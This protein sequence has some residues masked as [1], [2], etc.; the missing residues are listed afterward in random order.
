MPPAGGG[1]TRARQRKRVPSPAAY[2]VSQGKAVQHVANQQ[3]RA[4]RPWQPTKTQLRSALAQRREHVSQGQAVR[5]VAKVQ[6]VLGPGKAPTVRSYHRREIA[7]ANRAQD[8]VDQGK[9]VEHAAHQQRAKRKAEAR[10]LA[11]ENIGKIQPPTRGVYNPKDVALYA[12]LIDKHG[13]SQASKIFKTHKEVRDAASKAKAVKVLEQVMRPGYASAGGARALVKGQGIKGVARGISRGAQ[14]KDRYLYSD[15]LKEAGVKNKTVRGVAGFGLDILLDPTTY[16]TFGAGSVA[17]KT[18]VKAAIRSAERGAQI[19]A[20]RLAPKVAAGDLTRKEAKAQVAAKGDQLKRSLLRKA[21]REGR[22]GGRKGLTVKVAGGKH[23][24]KAIRRAGLESKRA[25]LAPV[26]RATAG[27]GR[28]GRFLTEPLRGAKSAEAGKAARSVGSE[29]H[30]GVRPHDITTK[31]FGQVKSLRREQRAESETNARRVAARANSLLGRLDPEEAKQVID[32]IEADKVGHLRSKPSR[33]V[34]RK[35]GRQ[36]RLPG[37]AGAAKPLKASKRHPIES[38]RSRATRQDPDR[39]YHVANDL[40]SD[41]RYLNR[42]G[43]RSGLLAGQVGKK[44]RTREMVE[45]SAKATP[46]RSTA[47]ARAALKPALRDRALARSALAQAETPA[48]KK[49]AKAAVQ[50]ADQRVANLRKPIQREAEGKQARGRLREIRQERFGKQGEAKGFFPRVREEDVGKRGLLERMAAGTEGDVPRAEPGGTKA[51]TAE[52]RQF[53]KTRAGLAKGSGDE[54]AVAESLTSDVRESL[55]RYGTSV[56]RAAGQRNLNT[57]VVQQ[58]GT[59]LPR[60]MS[61]GEFEAL[62]KEGKSVYRVRRGELEKVTDFEMAAKASGRHEATGAAPAQA[63]KGGVK[64]ATVKT[65]GKQ[66]TGQAKA[67]GGGGQYAIVDNAV[68]REARKTTP[69]TQ[70]PTLQAFDRVQGGF[71]S[72]ALATPGYLVRNVLGDAFNAAVHE[73]PFTLA[74]NAVKSQKALHQLGRWEKAQGRFEKALPKDLKTIKLT[75]EQAAAIGTTKTEIPAMHAALL[76]ERNGVIRQGRFLELVEEGGTRPKGTHAWQNAVKRVEDSMRMT[77]FMGGLQRGLKPREAAANASKIHFDYGDLTKAEKGVFRR[78]MPFYTFTSRNLPLQAQAI[79]KRPGRYA[80]VQKA[81][82]EGRKQSGLPVGY[83]G[84]QNPYEARQ[85][86]LPIKFG[87]K[88]FTLSAAAPFTDLND[89]VGLNPLHP[90]EAADTATKRVGEMLSPF[91][92]T[93]P[94]LAFNLSLFYRDQI[95]RK[96]EPLT[97]APKW[98]QELA[99]LE[100]RFGKIVGYQPNYVPPEGGSTPGWGRK[101]DYFF[102]QIAP[103][104]IQPLIEGANLGV[105]QGENARGMEKWQRLLAAA[106]PRAIEYDPVKVAVEKTYTR[107]DKIEKRLDILRR[108]AHPSEKTESGRPVRVSAEHPTPEFTKLYEEQKKLSTQLDE[109]LRASR[110]G[111]F[112]GGEEVPK[113]GAATQKVGRALAGRKRLP[114]TRGLSTGRLALPTTR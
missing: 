77:T 48:Q 69:V 4:A 105:Q 68:V 112:V 103:G 34:T 18:A 86:G 79:V 65:T 44:G 53:R 3:R 23:V 110:P 22:T 71:K 54:R 57:K 66:A 1:R 109:G 56:A 84:G 52:R 108:T 49:A 5:R 85:L 89:L 59:K 11:G 62:K 78:L 73:N 97:R 100:P 9:A 27:A 31:H 39:L 21:E 82:E 45:L 94:E 36:V 101:A 14:L 99:K 47:A 19:E 8:Y 67:V 81:R 20:K 46:A 114:T 6:K 111:G 12:G 55:S 35:G 88:T 63:V 113:G 83:E 10:K 80:A 95:E 41:L 76:A 24:R 29:L 7:A 72:L 17:E 25:P 26:T 60:N 15:V 96:S 106:G 104:P 37:R 16:V 87:D 42:V 61:R 93:L 70:S 75:P 43:R 107:L 2:Y 38:V 33:V 102:R 40:R 58:L 50:R 74:R 98:A 13:L 28:A 92:K 51:G 90:V 91:V 64:G 32:A 30:A